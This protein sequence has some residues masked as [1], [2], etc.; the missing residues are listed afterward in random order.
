[1]HSR[2]VTLN[3]DEEVGV[4]LNTMNERRVNGAPVV[5]KDNNLIGIVVK[6]D[7]YKF[8]TE[9][10]RYPKYPLDRAM[11]YK[12]ITATEDEDIVTVA[13][14]LRRHDIMAVPVVDGLKV[15]GLVSLEDIVDYFINQN[16]NE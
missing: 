13:K 5:D 12:V 15:I 6:H 2:F 7:L 8:L 4:A 16:T 9:R 1:M 10:G 3:G 14:R 11:T